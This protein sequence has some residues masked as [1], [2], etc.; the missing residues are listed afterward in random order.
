MP[1]YGCALL[2]LI[3]ILAFAMFSRGA[4]LPD[5][6]REYDIAMNMLQDG[7]FAVPHM[8]GEAFLEKPPLLYWVAASFMKLTNDSILAAR[9]QNILWSSIVILA[10]GALAGRMAEA[11]D[12]DMR[13]QSA[14]SLIA[15]LAAGTMMLLLQIEIRLST[16][17]PVLAAT[18]LAWL[19]MWSAVHAEQ[20]RDRMRWY[21]I[22]AC[23]FAAAFFGKN[24]F[25]WVTP[26]VGMG[27]WIIWERRWRV[28][29]QPQLYI[30][31]AVLVAVLGLWALFVLRQPQGADALKVIVWDNTFGRFQATASSSGYEFGHRNHPLK[32]LS[33]LPMFMLPWTFCVIAALRWAW[34]ELKAN[35]PGVSAIRFSICSFIPGIVLLTMSATSRDT[36]Y[37]PS[38]LALCPLLGVWAQQRSADRI[39]RLWIRINTFSARLAGAFLVC[40]ALMLAILQAQPPGLWHIV[41]GVV[42]AIACWCGWKAMRLTNATTAAAAHVPV[43]LCGLIALEIIAFPAIDQAQDLTPFAMHAAADIQGSEVYLFCADETTRSVLDS[44]AGARPK[45][46][47]GE[48]LVRGLLAV[49]SKQ[50]FLAQSGLTRQSAQ[51]RALLQSLHATALLRG[52]SKVMPAERLE[53]LGLRPVVEWSIPGGRSYGLYAMPSVPLATNPPV[54]SGIAPLDTDDRQKAE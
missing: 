16:D 20:P 38:I 54:V 8:A 7:N 23:A 13:M 6:P 49:D 34:T 43:W 47:C 9:A 51:S 3:P 19:A 27:A 2:I 45:N 1:W 29:R 24:I 14:V 10:V 31:L 18:A 44:T 21:L 33:S 4:W 41:A 15:A 30:A 11:A 52:S 17:A 53:A 28:L 35:G 40:A 26:F 5:E 37:G 25:G 50:M 32:Y 39:E 48:D 42:M 36:Y 46:V 22:L 12:C